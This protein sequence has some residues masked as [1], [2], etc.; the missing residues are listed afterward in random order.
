MAPGAFLDR[1]NLTIK[2]RFEVMRMIFGGHID[3]Y[4]YHLVGL[5]DELLADLLY[6]SGFSGVCKVADFGLFEDTSGWL[7]KGVAIS[8]NM[9]CEKPA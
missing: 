8:I 4:D 9:I 6:K 3:K 5:N 1:M 2:D 7:F